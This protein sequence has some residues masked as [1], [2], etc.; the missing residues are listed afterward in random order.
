MYGIIVTRHL[1][2]ES[3]RRMSFISF[4]RSGVEKKDASSRKTVTG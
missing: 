4:C 2:S 1:D 3:G